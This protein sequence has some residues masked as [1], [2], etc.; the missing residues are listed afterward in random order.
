MAA[1][2]DIRLRRE[3]QGICASTCPVSSACAPCRR[4][5]KRLGFL[6]LYTDWKG[7]YWFKSEKSLLTART[8]SLA[9]L[10]SLA[11]EPGEMLVT[12]GSRDRRASVPPHLRHAGRVERG[13][14]SAATGPEER[15]LLEL[16]EDLFLP[17]R[18]ES[19]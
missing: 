2:Q 18:R 3:W 12:R 4:R 1:G 11:D 7:N 5:A 14:R 16:D 17:A 9:S 8:E 19:D 13:P 10:E 6:T 15:A